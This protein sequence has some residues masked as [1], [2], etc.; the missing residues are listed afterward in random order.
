MHNYRFRDYLRDKYEQMSVVYRENF[1][2][3]DW[4]EAKDGEHLKK[5][6]KDYKKWSD[7]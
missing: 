6:I 7:K 5:L 3:R 1:E 2:F 4:L